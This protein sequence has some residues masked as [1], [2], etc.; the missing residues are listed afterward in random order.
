MFLRE[1]SS[2]GSVSISWVPCEHAGAVFRCYVCVLQETASYAGVSFEMD[3]FVRYD[4]VRD[5][6]Y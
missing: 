6:R 1:T 3:K 4:I 2:D 5:I